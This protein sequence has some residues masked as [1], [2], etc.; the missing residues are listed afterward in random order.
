M[1]LRFTQ[2]GT[3]EGPAVVQPCKQSAAGRHVDVIGREA[4]ACEG[5][6]WNGPLQQLAGVGRS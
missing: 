1:L 3:W 2:Q 4:Q 5:S 6:K